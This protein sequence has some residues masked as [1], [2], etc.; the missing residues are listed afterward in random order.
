MWWKSLHFSIASFECETR[1]DKHMK[2]NPRALFELRLL[3]YK[4]WNLVVGAGV[5]FLKCMLDEL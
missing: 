5:R 2:I 1:R 3:T 4:N